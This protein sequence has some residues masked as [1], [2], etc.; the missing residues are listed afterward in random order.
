MELWPFPVEAIPVLRSTVVL[1]G[2]TPFKTI[3]EPIFPNIS[4]PDVAVI[5]RVVI[6]VPKIGCPTGSESVAAAPRITLL[7]PVFRVPFVTIKA[8]F[9]VIS[10]PSEMPFALLSVKLLKVIPGNVVLAADPPIDILELKLPNND[11]EP[12]VTRPFRLSVCA[13]IVNVPLVRISEPLIVTSVDIIT[14]TGLAIVILL[15]VAP[16]IV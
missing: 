14:P 1:P 4:V 3:S 12:I 8:L 11:P 7:I 10:P 5:F 2:A 16:L 15:H 9:T 6:T 13:P